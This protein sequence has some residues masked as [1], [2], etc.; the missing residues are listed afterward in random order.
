MDVFKL[1]GIIDLNNKNALKALDETSDKGK[2]TDGKLNKFFGA[3]GK[4][5]LALGKVVATGVVTG[6]VALAGLGVAA[7]KSYADYEQLV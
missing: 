2:E 3:I 1:Q 6:T 7:V 4:G 5:A